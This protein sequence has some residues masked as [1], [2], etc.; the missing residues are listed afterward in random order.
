MA[1]YGLFWSTLTWTP[2]PS[3]VGG[4]PRVP[5]D[6]EV[7]G[8]HWA[9]LNSSDR[10][11]KMMQDPNLPRPVGGMVEQHLQ[12]FRRCFGGGRV[13]GGSWKE[14]P[15]RLVTRYKRSHKNDDNLAILCNLFGIVKCSNSQW[16]PTKGSKG[17]LSHEK[18]TSYFPLN[19]G[20]LVG[21][22]IMVL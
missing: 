22:L 6:V 5:K 15:K 1:I 11:G 21:I 4:W 12:E 10:V 13:R 14:S 18:K 19:P 3:Q 17:H 2:K 16:P 9:R 8:G 7:L 20:W